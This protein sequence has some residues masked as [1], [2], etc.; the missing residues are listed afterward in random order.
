M[1]SPWACSPLTVSGP[2]KPIGHL[3]HAGEVLDVALG[4]VRIERVAVEML[5]LHP[6]ERFDESLPLPD[7]LRGAVVLLRIRNGSG[8][9]L[10]LPHMIPDLDRQAADSLHLDGDLDVV[11]ALGDHLPRGPEV[12][13]LAEGKVLRSLRRDVGRGPPAAIT[14]VH[15]EL[16]RGD[17]Q[18]ADAYPD[19]ASQRDVAEAVLEAEPGAVGGVGQASRRCRAA[20]AGVGGPSSWAPGQRSVSP[21]WH[22][23]GAEEPPVP[24]WAKRRASGGYRRRD[25]ASQRRMDVSS[26]LT[27]PRNC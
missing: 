4:D 18:L 1:K 24:L 10:R 5:Q 16:A 12:R 21:M 14:H 7:H 15:L 11:R 23:V 13:D 6:A 20:G 25:S 22:V 19:D 27:S 26:C 8:P 3:G 9:L 2:A 17:L